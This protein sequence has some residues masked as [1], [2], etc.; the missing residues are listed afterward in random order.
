MY[1]ILLLYIILCTI[2]F[3]GD[4]E[5]KNEHFYHRQYNNDNINQPIIKKK[6]N[7]ISP[8]FPVFLLYGYHKNNI[9]ECHIWEPI[10]E[11]GAHC[12]SFNQPVY[13]NNDTTKLL[14]PANTSWHLGRMLNASINPHVPECSEFLGRLTLNFTTGDFSCLCTS[15]LFTGP[16]CDQPSDKL[17][18][19]NNCKRVG[20]SKNPLVTDVS[21]FDPVEEGICVEC[22]VTGAVPVIESVQTGPSCWKPVKLLKKKKEGRKKKKKKKKKKIRPPLCVFDVL[23]GRHTSPINKYVS[24][25]GCSCD[26]HNGYVEGYIFGLDEKEISDNN[27][28]ND[29]KVIIGNACIKIA[30][31]TEKLEYHRTDI[32]YYTLVNNGNPLQTHTYK[33]EQLEPPFVS[34]L[35]LHNNNKLI[36]SKA[37]NNKLINSKAVAKVELLIDQPLGNFKVHSHDWL[38]RNFRKHTQMYRRRKND[39]WPGVTTKGGIRLINHYFRRPV[40]IPISTVEFKIGKGYEKKYWYELTNF[41]YL[42]NAVWGHPVIY[43]SK[44]EWADTFTLNSVGVK[45]GYYVGLTL[46]TRPEDYLKTVRVDTRTVSKNRF[47]KVIPPDYYRDMTSEEEIAS[48]KENRRRNSVKITRY[49]AFVP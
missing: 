40:T 30:K 42:T 15:N 4:L 35:S 23:T 1:L 39:T 6:L 44:D 26:Y 16:H 46:L 9:D 18:R 34:L 21:L 8:M 33:Y 2:Y 11:L 27:N 41:R 12:I 45:E 14:W 24:G 32:L 17:L 47:P 3:L 37:V 19:E 10:K 36:N 5:D 31:N 13:D 43:G 28:S 25:Y 38:N 7:G 49:P 20:W 29:N 48:E 22:T